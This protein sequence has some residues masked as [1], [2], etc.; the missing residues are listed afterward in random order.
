MNIWINILYIKCILHFQLFTYNFE[1]INSVA[2]NPIHLYTHN[3]INI[4]II[5]D[6]ETSKSVRRYYS[7]SL[8]N[9]NPT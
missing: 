9:T 8:L 2:Y 4:A 5:T 6:D 7:F 3:Y 1:I